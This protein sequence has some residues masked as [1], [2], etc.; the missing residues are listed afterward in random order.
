MRQLTEHWDDDSSS[1]DKLSLPY[2]VY[3][4]P[5]DELCQSV[6]WR[7]LLKNASGLALEA[8]CGTG[9]NSLVLTKK[10]V[11]PVLLDFSKDTIRYCKRLFSRCG[12]EGFFVVGDLTRMPFREMVFDFVHSD[13]T[14]EHV[15]DYGNA[16]K[17]IFRITKKGG[18]IFITVPNKLKLDGSDLHAKI[19]HIDYIN[20][21]FTP[22]QFT[23]DFNKY[24]KIEKVFGYDI[25]SP[26]YMV[27]VRKIA[28]II[29]AVGN[30]QSENTT[31]HEQAARSAAICARTEAGSNF[32]ELT[33][34][35]WLE[36]KGLAQRSIRKW[37]L[38]EHS[39]LVSF[40]LGLLAKKCT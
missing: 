9:K 10:G 32:L 22:N 34:F 40:N 29:P 5:L 7:N 4:A 24:F 2:R 16:T 38:A 30:N 25:L 6:F 23:K 17:E 31:I 21:S 12:C 35:N 18:D 11:T 37:L 14:L 28:K 27:I 36:R 8:G 1:Y 33:V 26:V 13:S 19:T 20:R 3:S 15:Q 39:T